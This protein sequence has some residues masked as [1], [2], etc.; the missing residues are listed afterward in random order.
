MET[1]KCSSCQETKEL[2][3][4]RRLTRSKDG[5]TGRC[6]ACIGAKEL[7]YRKTMTAETRAKRH[8][9]AVEWKANNPDKVKEFY[10]RY[11]AKH[12]EKEKARTAKWR[13]ENKE[14]VQ[15]TS[16]KWRTENKEY[17]YALCETWRL[18]NKERVNA[19]RRE[20]A[21]NNPDKLREFAYR[22]RS[23]NQDKVKSHN[24]RAQVKRIANLTDTY[25]AGLFKN[26]MNN[27]GVQ[28]PPELLEAKRQYLA[29]KRKLGE[30]K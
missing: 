7:Q 2:V 14:H 13:A 6:S 8:N 24:K 22:W 10:A 21:K 17:F 20:W 9:T 27:W 28:V 5:F 30:L 19:T 1:K 26:Q 25:I 12:K 4:F 3:L 15:K 18:N 23:K 11:Y 29:I 16:R